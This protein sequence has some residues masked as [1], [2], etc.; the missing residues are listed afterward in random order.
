VC[1]KKNKILTAVEY[2]VQIYSIEFD[3]NRSIVPGNRSLLLADRRDKINRR[4]KTVNVNDRLKIS[5]KKVFRRPFYSVLQN[6]K[7]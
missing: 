6:L 4:L 1:P 2:L 3:G 5:L 7:G